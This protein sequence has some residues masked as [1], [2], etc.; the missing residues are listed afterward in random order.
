MFLSVT[1]S[2]TRHV[3]VVFLAHK[4][5]KIKLI[6]FNYDLLYWRNQKKC[7][8]QII[9]NYKYV[10]IHTLPNVL[11]LITLCY[12]AHYITISLKYITNTHIFFCFFLHTV[13]VYGK[14]SHS[15]SNN[16]SFKITLQDLSLT[17]SNGNLDGFIE[18]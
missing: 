18:A 2:C 1:N 10:I 14:C 7:K 15:Y 5:K 12:F 4:W 11:V 16:L 8:L 3:N 6:Y 17:S 9:I 13:V